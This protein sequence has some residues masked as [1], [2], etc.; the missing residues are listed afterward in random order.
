M[1]SGMPGAVFNPVGAQA[2]QAITD[3]TS[4]SGEGVDTPN[5]LTLQG[6]RELGTS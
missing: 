2:Q 6:K 4:V 3:K 5:E 1:P